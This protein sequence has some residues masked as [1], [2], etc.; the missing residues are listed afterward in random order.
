MNRR[1][2]TVMCYALVDKFCHLATVWFFSLCQTLCFN[3]Q[4]FAYK[5]VLLKSIQSIYTCYEY[6]YVPKKR[7]RKTDGDIF[8]RR[9]WDGNGNDGCVNN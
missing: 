5:C 1:H 3:A 6:F 4:V 8:H 7:R 9:E 2:L